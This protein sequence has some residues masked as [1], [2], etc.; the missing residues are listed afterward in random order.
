MPKNMFCV[1]GDYVEMDLTKGKTCKVDFVDWLAVYLHSW[2]TD[3][4]YASTMLPGRQKILLH[5]L[6]T[7]YPQVDHI[8]R[9]GWDNRQSNL[10]AANQS[11][12]M[13]NTAPKSLSGF[14]GVRKVHASWQACIRSEGVYTYLG[15][16]P[17]PEEAARAYDRSALALNGEFAYL[18][19][20][21]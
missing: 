13:C 6:I 17:T 10:R 18:N 12:N 9:D 4:T 7:S 19:F 16:Y 2:C 11:Q 15:A 20:P 8:N 21:D 5:K 3:K 1:V 14:K